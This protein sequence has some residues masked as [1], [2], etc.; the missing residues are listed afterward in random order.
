VAKYVS[1]FD[2]KSE[3]VKIDD[4]R[5]SEEIPEDL[6][7]ALFLEKF[8]NRYGGKKIEGPNARGPDFVGIKD[9]KRVRIEI[10]KRASDFLMHNREPREYDVVYCLYKDADLPVQQ[11]V[12]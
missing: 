12:P 5:Q 3:L 4:I 7:R 2:V 6:L 9:G 11:P 10:E 1:S 8:F